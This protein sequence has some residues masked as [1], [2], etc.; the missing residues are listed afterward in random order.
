MGPTLLIT[1]DEPEIVELLCDLLEPLKDKLELQILSANN[2]QEALEIIKNNQV[3]AV[4]SDIN[5][6]K[7]NGLDLLKEIRKLGKETPLVFLTAYADKNNTLEALRLG[8][9]DF[10]EKPMEEARVLEVVEGAV[11][12]GVKLRS[13]ETQ[14]DEIILS[15]NLSPEKEKALREAQKA[16][17]LSKAES[18]KKTVA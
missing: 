12:L 9:M 18:K 1:D 3:D 10:L 16:L 11:G 7:L 13:L 6:P 4:L 15:A 17:N 8:A 14:V 2:G 5:M